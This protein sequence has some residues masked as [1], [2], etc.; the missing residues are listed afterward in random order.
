MKRLFF[1]SIW[2]VLLAG[3][4]SVSSHSPERAALAMEPIPPTV[5]VVRHAEAYQNV[6]HLP[7]TSR[8]KLDSLTSR[9]IQQAK[10]TG[11][12][13]KNKNIVSVIA[14]PTWRT[15]QTARIIAEEVGLNGVFSV[16]PAFASMKKGQTPEGKPV[17]WSWRRKQWKAGKDPRP[18]EG[19]SLEDA[20]NRAVR[21]VEALTGKY[22]GKG[23]VIVTHSDICAG[24]AGHAENTPF[25]QR[26]TKH[27]IDLGS[28][29]EIIIEPKGSWKLL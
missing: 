9:G 21:A 10:K 2:F 16:N 23:V 22:P 1:L 15:R 13:L 6:V 7:G 11:A 18:Q 5:F 12:Y 27:G 19:E 3:I 24:L 14:S 29:I 28:V 26:Y 20:T 8:E 4:G 17:T 25:Y